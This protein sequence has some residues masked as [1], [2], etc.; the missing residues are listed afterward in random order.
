MLHVKIIHVFKTIQRIFNY[1]RLPTHLRA[2]IKKKIDNLF[3][4]QRLK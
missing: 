1:L 4:R 2:N 3:Y